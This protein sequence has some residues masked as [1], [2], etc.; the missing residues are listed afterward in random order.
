[1]HNRER[2]DTIIEV[3]FAVTVFSLVAVGG[4]T[5]MNQGAATAQRSLEIGLAREQIDSQADALRY[6][7]SAYIANG[8][9]P[10]T[11]PTKQSPWERV[12]AMAYNYDDASNILGLSNIAAASGTACQSPPDG[13]GKPFAIDA[14]KLDPPGTPNPSNPAPYLLTGQYDGGYSDSGTA[15]TKSL[16]S[17][18]ATYAK[19]LSPAVDGVSRAAADGIW[20]QAVKSDSTAPVG[21]YDFHIMACWSSPGQSVP[22]T[23]G[24]IVRLYNA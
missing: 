17:A 1:M 19:I 16:F 8:A 14:S 3:I 15:A 6:I 7:H 20:V 9:T 18:P 23:L 2:G 24:T 11:D 4:I 13:T 12:I 21:Y 22:S 5:I 10:S